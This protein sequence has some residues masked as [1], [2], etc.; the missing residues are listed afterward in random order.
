M[1]IDNTQSEYRVL[2]GCLLNSSFQLR[3]QHGAI[4]QA[5]DIVKP[6]SLLTCLFGSY[7]SS[8]IL[9]NSAIPH[10][11]TLSVE[12]I[13]KDTGPALQ[14]LLLEGPG[15]RGEVRRECDSCFV[16]VSATCGENS[17]EDL[18]PADVDSDAELVSELLSR[19]HGSTLYSSMLP[20][21]H[22]MLK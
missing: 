14:G 2:C 10:D 6:W 16:R 19:F 3:H 18:L 15:V 8:H 22:S 9:R 12:L 7:Q 20:F 17:R 13:E 5:S 4:W 21:V 1:Q 11:A